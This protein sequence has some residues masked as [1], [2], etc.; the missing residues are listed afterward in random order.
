MWWHF[1][2]GKHDLITTT[3]HALFSWT[4]ADPAGFTTL[5][6]STL[7]YSLCREG[8]LGSGCFNGGFAASFFFLACAFDQGKLTLM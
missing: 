1:A 7:A 5:V 3:N 8:D 4:P 6:R 2:L